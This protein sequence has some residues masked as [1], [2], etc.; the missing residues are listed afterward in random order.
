VKGSDVVEWVETR[1][2]LRSL[3]FD[4]RG[5][6]RDS[7]RWHQVSGASRLKLTVPPI[8]GLAKNHL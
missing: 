8:F 1:F 3:R 6:Q 4:P 5:S 7:L 2:G